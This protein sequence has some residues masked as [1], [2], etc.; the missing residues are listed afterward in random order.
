MPAWGVVIVIINLLISAGWV[1]LGICEERDRKKRIRE[2]EKKFRLQASSQEPARRQT[3]AIV[4]VRAEA[5]LTPWI[6]SSGTLNSDAAKAYIE[7]RKHD[8]SHQM[9]ETLLKEGFIDFQTLTDK[10]GTCILR[11]LLKV[12][13]PERKA[14]QEREEIMEEWANG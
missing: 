10:E 8:L 2:M 9:A 3:L 13:R 6:C 4:P 7:H 14:I 1:A 11:A 5:T 12:V